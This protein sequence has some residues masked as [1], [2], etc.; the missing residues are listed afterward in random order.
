MMKTDSVG[1]ESYQEVMTV[2]DGV[3][4]NDPAPNSVRP[5]A[6]PA[7][8]DILQ[9][10]GGNMRRYFILLLLTTVTLG[11][12]LI[13]FACQSSPK[14]TITSSPVAPDTLLPW[15][16]VGRYYGQITI[17]DY[18]KGTRLISPG[19]ATLTIDSTAPYSCANSFSITIDLNPYAMYTNTFYVNGHPLSLKWDCSS[20]RYH[21]ITSAKCDG[22][23]L[24]GSQDE[25]R[26]DSA[27]AHMYTLVFNTSR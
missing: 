4:Y 9:L 11:G 13:G 20:D 12:I 18:V 21:F 26:T 23:S 22:S 27:N 8:S 17:D 16:V 3:D 1:G 7:E 2:L 6:S 19:S 10:Y 24:Y 14:K 15:Q 5:L 25:Y